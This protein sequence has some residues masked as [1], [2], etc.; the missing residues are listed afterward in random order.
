MNNEAKKI[1]VNVDGLS[2][3]EKQRVNE[4]L[5][6]IKN[7]RMC[8]STSS[9]NLDRVTTLLGPSSDGINVGFS[10]YKNE[11]PTHSPQQVLEMAAT[12]TEEKKKKVQKAFFDAGILWGYHGKKYKFLNT[13]SDM[14]EVDWSKGTR[15][16]YIQ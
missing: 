4:A 6:K 12:C 15:W 16:C 5:A 10:Y 9:F 13:V 2:N 8:E 3:K 11:N 14:K 1:I 7:I